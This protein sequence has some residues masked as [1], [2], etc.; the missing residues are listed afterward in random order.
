MKLC[1]RLRQ[2][3]EKP[4]RTIWFPPLIPL[5]IAGAEQLFHVEAN[6]LRNREHVV[7]DIR[8]NFK[9]VTSSGYSQSTSRASD[10]STWTIHGRQ[11]IG[12]HWVKVLLHI[13]KKTLFSQ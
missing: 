6:D 5:R 10:N 4:N 1:W 11:K 9:W 2:S 12:E 8:S 7:L 13:L 3:G